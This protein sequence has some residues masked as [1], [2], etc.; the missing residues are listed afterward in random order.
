MKYLSIIEQIP[1]LLNARDAE[2]YVAGPTMLAELQNKW[3][4]K[5]ID[6]RHRLTTYDRHDIDMAIERKKLAES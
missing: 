5:P 4:L 1:R 6:K 3:G 2:D